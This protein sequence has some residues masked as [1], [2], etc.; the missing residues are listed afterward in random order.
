MNFGPKLEAFRKR[1]DEI[2]PHWALV[3]EAGGDP[4]PPLEVYPGGKAV[5]LAAW[6]TWAKADL[7][8]PLDLRGK[9]LLPLQDIR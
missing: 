8:G 5:Q 7:P 2:R 1:Y 4:V 3:P 9:T 6:Q